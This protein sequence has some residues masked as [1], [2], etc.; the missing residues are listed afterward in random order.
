MFW[1]LIVWHRLESTNNDNTLTLDWANL[2]A[3]VMSMYALNIPLYIAQEIRVC[4][5]KNSMS[6][7]FLCLVFALCSDYFYHDLS[8]HPSLDTIS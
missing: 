7:S 2:V 8:L 3:S 5:I 4:S 1:W 6:I